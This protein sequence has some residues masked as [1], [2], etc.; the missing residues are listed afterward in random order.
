MFDERNSA[1]RTANIN[2]YLAWAKKQASELKPGKNVTVA[3]KRFDWGMSQTLTQAKDVSGKE[4]RGSLVEEGLKQLVNS[5]TNGQENL[6]SIHS[7]IPSGPKRN[8]GYFQFQTHET[9]TKVPG[10]VFGVEHCVDSSGEIIGYV[11]FLK[12]N[13]ISKLPKTASKTPPSMDG[14]NFW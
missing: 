10:L 13:K 14:S 5:L 9:Q 12:A 6:E 7:K 8:E 1:E 4:L 11:Y 2:N 3:L